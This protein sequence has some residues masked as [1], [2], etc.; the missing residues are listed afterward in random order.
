MNFPIKTLIVDDQE[1]FRDSIQALLELEH[2]IE[3]VGMATN[4]EEALAL[5]RQLQPQVVLMDL[6]MPVMN[7]TEATRRI[8]G[9]HTGTRVLIL[10]IF[11][12]EPEVFDAL[13]AG[14]A[15]YLLKGMPLA[16]LA[17][18]IR[19]VAAGGSY[20]QPT[21]AAQVVREFV[22][23]FHLATGRTSASTI[24]EA[25]SHRE[26]EILHHL[27]LGKSNKEIAASLDITEGTVKNHM[28]NILAKLQVQDR[29]AAALRARD[30]GLI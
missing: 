12:D 10:T 13:L 26:V 17:E 22:R 18:A 23:L 30:L 15:G 27:M 25:L 2:S 11:G 19:A 7:G 3:V 1:A 16:Q 20:L 14:A 8:V 21:V 24:R 28:S 9:E 29:T 4:G 5:T 6:R